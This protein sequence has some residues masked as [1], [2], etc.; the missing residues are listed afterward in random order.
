MN[1]IASL[2]IPGLGQACQGRPFTALC[3][4][5]I[6]LVVWV[7]SFGLLGWVVNLCSAFGAAAWDGKERARERKELAHLRQ[8][9]AKLDTPRPT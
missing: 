1:A 6:G 9:A 5:L 7:G 4:F 2:I 3:H 8:A